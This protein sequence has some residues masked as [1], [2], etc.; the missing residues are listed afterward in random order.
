MLISEIFKTQN[1]KMPLESADKESLFEEM[2][3]FLVKNEHF[4][5]KKEILNS[6]WERERKM[7]TGISP[8]IAIPHAYLPG[9]KKTVG[10]LGISINGIE[11]EAL[12]GKPVNVVLFI[13]GDKNKPNEHLKI[14]KDIALILKRDEFLPQI[15]KCTTPQQVSDAFIGFENLLEI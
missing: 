9:M 7:T 4:D 5:N 3:D 1:V 13:L 14:L 12:D 2:V 10:V 15:M 8:H 11:Y 6:L